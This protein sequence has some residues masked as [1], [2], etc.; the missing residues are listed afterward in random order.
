MK[1]LLLALFILSF[2]MQASCSNE[3]VSTLQIFNLEELKQMMEN[4]EDKANFKNIQIIRS[5]IPDFFSQFIN[6]GN[7]FLKQAV[8]EE[9]NTQKFQL[10]ID[11]GVNINQ[12]NGAGDTVLHEAAMLCNVKAI[13]LL[14][15]AGA[16]VTI[17]NNDNYTA[18]ELLYPPL[19][20]IFDRQYRFNETKLN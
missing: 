5:Y 13:Q 11:L 19:Q 8:L 10:L 9:N 14:I 1:K 15:A 17:E 12:Q 18:R 7:T 6:Q 2:C 4:I 20:S 3:E 16:D